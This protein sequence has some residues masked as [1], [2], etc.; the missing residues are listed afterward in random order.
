MSLSEAPLPKTSWTA[1][2]YNHTPDS[3]HGSLVHSLGQPVQLWSL[4]DGV[5]EPNSLRPA[6]LFELPTVFSLV[7]CSNC[8]QLPADFSFASCVE[9]LEDGQYLVL[10]L[11]RG[12]PQLPMVVI[13]EG[14]KV[15]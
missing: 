2:L 1:W 12:D 7:I 5:L 14:H 13:Y 15:L 11:Q 8:F 3:L 6:V 4:R 9:R 10:R